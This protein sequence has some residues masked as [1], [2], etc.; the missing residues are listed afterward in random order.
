MLI[1]VDDDMFNSLAVVEIYDGFVVLGDFVRSNDIVLDLGSPHR[2]NGFLA[3]M[4]GGEKLCQLVLGWLLQVDFPEAEDGILVMAENNITSCICLFDRE[5]VER[6]GSHGGT[7]LDQV[8][9]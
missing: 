4:L 1:G 9:E 8:E 3:R 7:V 5:D 6:V 2:R